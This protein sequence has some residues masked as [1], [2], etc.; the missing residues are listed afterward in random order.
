MSWQI[1]LVV[2]LSPSWQ[3]VRPNAVS[4]SVSSG[5]SVSFGAFKTPESRSQRSAGGHVS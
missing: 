5:D 3:P 4:L 1:V 2:F